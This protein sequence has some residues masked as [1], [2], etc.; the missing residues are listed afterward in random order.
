[1]KFIW[2]DFF[3]LNRIFTKVLVLLGLVSCLAC[4]PK[5]K[6]VDANSPS[7]ESPSSAEK[8]SADAAEGRSIYRT[9]CIACHSPDPTKDTAL[10]PALAGS[11]AELLE[12]R[13]VNGK[14]PLGYTPKR[15]TG[16]M[17][18]FPHLKSKIPQL[19]AY[20]NHVEKN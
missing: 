16:Q 2:L 1:M 14:Y 19:Q 7:A 17:P 3:F 11:S 12:A 5:E 18:L 10:G 13:L 20:L 8:L 9:N 6:P 15:T 4:T